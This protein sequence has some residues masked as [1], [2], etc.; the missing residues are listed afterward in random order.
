MPRKAKRKRVYRTKEETKEQ[1][2]IK[3]KQKQ[4]QE[5][6][7]N[8]KVGSSGSTAPSTPTIISNTHYVPQQQNND[9][10]LAFLMKSFGNRPEQPVVNELPQTFRNTNVGEDIPQQ[11]LVKQIQRPNKS[12]KTSWDNMSDISHPDD[13]S[14]Q[15]S[16]DTPPI[17]R[18]IPIQEEILLK[19][20]LTRTPKRIPYN[21][22]MLSEDE[23]GVSTIPVQYPTVI[24]NTQQITDNHLERLIRSSGNEQEKSIIKDLP[25]PFQSASIGEDIPTQTLVDQATPRKALPTLPPI[26]DALVNKADTVDQATEPA[27]PAE[28]NEKNVSRRLKEVRPD[29]NEVTSD[30][31]DTFSP[32]KL[33]EQKLQNKH[34]QNA[35]S[36]IFAGD[37]NRINDYIKDFKVRKGLPKDTYFKNLNRQQLLQVLDDLKSQEL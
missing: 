24:R 17:Q 8:I 26:K 7:V 14:L 37:K 31:Q 12:A 27:Y 34:L 36:S 11:S 5:Q 9:N 1:K 30:L 20:R 22:E 21:A 32:G 29:D 33:Q 25:K 28:L 16:E 4:K 15:I 3:Q 13:V 23:A 10:L 2:R 18:A 19:P 35:I 6:T